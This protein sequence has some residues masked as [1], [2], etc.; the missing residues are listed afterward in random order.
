MVAKSLEYHFTNSGQEIL[1]ARSGSPP[2]HHQQKRGW[3]RRS[4]GA[5]VHPPSPGTL[6][7]AARTGTQGAVHSHRANTV[8]HDA[9]LNCPALLF[10]S[11]DTRPSASAGADPCVMQAHKSRHAVRRTI[12]TAWLAIETTTTNAILKRRSPL[13]LLTKGLVST[14]TAGTSGEAPAGERFSSVLLVL[15]DPG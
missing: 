15:P 8:A 14:Q 1:R 6:A 9:P 10:G 11:R 13:N 5:G 2:D 4:R 7:A 3:T 12:A